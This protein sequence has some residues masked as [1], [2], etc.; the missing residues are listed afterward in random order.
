MKQVIPRDRVIVALAFLAAGQQLVLAHRRGPEDEV[1]LIWFQ[2]GDTVPSVRAVGSR[3]KEASLTCGESTVL[4]V[5]QSEC[6]SCEDVA[7]IWKDWTK[8]AG[9]GLPLAAISSEPHEAARTYAAKY[10]WKAE[11]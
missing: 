1:P 9:P 8:A 6:G 3:G 7:T 4:L 5:F 2:A 10:E 11:V